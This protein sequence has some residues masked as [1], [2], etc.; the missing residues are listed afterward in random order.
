MN[1]VHTV[2]D[3]GIRWFTINVAISATNTEKTGGSGVSVIPNKPYEVLNVYTGAMLFGS[4]SLRVTNTPT[5]A[6]GP[7]GY[8]VTNQYR[9]DQPNPIKLMESFY[10]TGAKQVASSVNESKYRGSLYLKGQKSME[11]MVEM[12]TLNSKVS[13]VLDIDRTNATVIRNLIDSP[14]GSDSEQGVASAVI[15]L[16]TPTAAFNLTAGTKLGFVVPND[17][18]KY[19]VRITSYN[20]NTGRI[21]VS[22]KAV[23]KLKDADFDNKAIPEIGVSSITTTD[24]RFFVPETSPDGSAYSKW[25]SRLFLFESDCDGIE[26]KLAACYYNKTDIRAY[27]RARPVGFEGNIS[28]ENW[29]PF[30]PSQSLNTASRDGII[31]S[32]VYS[33]LPDNVNAISV[34][35]SLNI[36]PKELQPD[37]WRSLTFSAQD[38]PAFDALEVKIVMTSDN[39][40]LAPLI[41]DMQLVVSE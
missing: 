7:S 12:G 1:T 22:G 19:G 14:K 35:N 16:N 13:P 24:G 9:P 28:Q 20:R 37:A 5:Q 17:I 40:A 10:Y 39:P 2:V 31:T 18:T 34:R 27:Y 3:S 15:T 41:D 4:S 30:N 29:T 33:G 25:I 32:A 26:M 38:L 8:N 6:A 21:V 11:I 23:N 36:D